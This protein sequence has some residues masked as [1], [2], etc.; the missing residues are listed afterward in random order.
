MSDVD[1]PV[2]VIQHLEPEGPALIADALARRG[3]RVEVIRTD[4]GD[5]VPT[6][7]T[8]LAGLVVMGGP[9][10]AGSD[11]DFPSRSAEIGLI[12]DAVDRGVP[13]LGICLGAQL[14]AVAGGASIIRGEVPEI[15]WGTATMEPGAADD[16]LF[17]RMTGELAV[18]HWHGETFG[19]PAGAVHL[20]SSAAYPNQAFRLGPTAWGLQFHLEVDGAAVE[21]FVSSFGDEADDPGAISRDASDQ[22]A[23]SVD[24]RDL[25][26]GRF[27]ALI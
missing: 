25:I 5:P 4:L 15:G 20:A 21:R 26:L 14:L 1:R 18:L 17:M 9:M 8:A 10:S 19:L 11:E 27:A 24:Q 6:D 23:R 3:H 22:L 16:P 13:V 2:V 12:A 7:A